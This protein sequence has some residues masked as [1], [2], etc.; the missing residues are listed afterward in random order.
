[1][2]KLEQSQTVENRTEQLEENVRIEQNNLNRKEQ[3]EKNC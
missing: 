1:M 2:E 3:L